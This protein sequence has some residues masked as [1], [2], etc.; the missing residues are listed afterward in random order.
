MWAP[1]EHAALFERPGPPDLMSPSGLVD[2]TQSASDRSTFCLSH[3]L[4]EIDKQPRWQLDRFL[5]HG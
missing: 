3:I 5:G 2:T 4:S 1:N